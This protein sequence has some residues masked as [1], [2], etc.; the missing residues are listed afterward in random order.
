MRYYIDHDD[1]ETQVVLALTAQRLRSY[2][3]RKVT[4]DNISQAQFD[5]YEDLLRELD[6]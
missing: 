3:V 2:V 6:K 5:V 4:E 1:P